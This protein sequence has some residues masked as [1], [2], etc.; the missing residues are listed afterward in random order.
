IPEGGSFNSFLITALTKFSIR[1]SITTPL[2]SKRLDPTVS[3]QENFP[4]ISHKFRGKKKNNFILAIAL[5]NIHLRRDP[6]QKL[7]LLTPNNSGISLAEAIINH[8]TDTPVIPP[9]SLEEH[10]PSRQRKR[11]SK[12]LTAGGLLTV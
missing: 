3:T 4:K 11:Q 10:T 6:T 8:S 12:D 9:S 7:G 5:I 2:D 1:P